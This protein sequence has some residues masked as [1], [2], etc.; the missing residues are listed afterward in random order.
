MEERSSPGTGPR[1]LTSLFLLLTLLVLASMGYSLWIVV[2][3]W[4][5]VGV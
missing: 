5:R 4:G 3:Y 1:L 2:E